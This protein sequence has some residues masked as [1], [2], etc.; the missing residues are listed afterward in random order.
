M[1][2]SFVYYVFHPT[3]SALLTA[4]TAPDLKL[5][6]GVSQPKVPFKLNEPAVCEEELPTEISLS[7]S[8]DQATSSPTVDNFVD[9][10]RPAPS[11]IS[12]SGL[13]V[14]NHRQE[15]LVGQFLSPGFTGK[16]RRTGLNRTAT[17]KKSKKEGSSC[18]AYST[19]AIEEEEHSEDD[20][21]SLPESALTVSINH[22]KEPLA[23]FLY[24]RFTR[25]RG[26]TYTD[27]SSTS[28]RIKPWGISL[29]VYPTLSIENKKFFDDDAIS[30]P[31]KDKKGKPFKV[32]DWSF[33]R[34]DPKNEKTAEN[35][36][37]LLENLKEC[38][39]GSDEES[40]FFVKKDQAA[41]FLSN[42]VAMKKGSEFVIPSDINISARRC[43]HYKILLEI[44][45]NKI[46]LE[47]YSFFSD[48]IV[49][50]M[51]ERVSKNFQNN[52][53]PDTTKRK[54]I[55]EVIVNITKISHLL[56]VIVLSFHKEHKHDILT[57]NEVEKTLNFFKDLW[58]KLDDGIFDTK[59][60]SW[61][62]KVHDILNFKAKNPKSKD[63][64][65]KIEARYLICWN[66]LN[67]WKAANNMNLEGVNGEIIHPITF[68]Q[69][70]NKMI[71]FSN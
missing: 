53:S 12:H 6:E 29:D 7:Y 71:F 60:E 1:R 25:K 24:P 65:S 45:D 46:N 54:T 30:V 63:W 18:D 13:T 69:L 20:A 32:Y 2:C 22:S 41:A 27:W 37:K 14:S 40:F 51:M 55:K 52:V 34:G 68:N 44:S 38:K 49:N 47:A 23:Q 66:F 61:Q 11:P 4:T 50:A 36:K 33:L 57:V 39:G 21:I 19:L 35:Q 17:S 28:K 43:Q 10:K 56:T 59:E 16:R 42:Y 58:V 3:I 67:Y 15:P 26:R 48:G 9:S 8:N 62:R 70:I 31:I 5:K 64:A